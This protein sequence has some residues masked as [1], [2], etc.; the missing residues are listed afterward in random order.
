MEKLITDELTKTVI[1]VGVA[2]AGTSALLVKLIML[3]TKIQ[4]S[5]K[6]YQKATLNYLLTAFL[7]FSAVAGLAYW[8]YLKNQQYFFFIY[9]AC[10][11]LLG[12]GHVYGMQKY[13]KWSGNSNAFW[14]ELLFTLIAGLLGSI[15]FLIVHRF[16]NPAGLTAYRFFSLDGM[17]LYMATSIGFFIIP[18]FVNQTF[19]SAITIPPRVLKQWYYPYNE[20]IEEPDED[21][22]K[23]LLVISFEFPKQ[24]SDKHHT[25]FRAKAPVDMEMGELF[26]YF[27]NDYNERH[28]HDQ[29]D[30]LREEGRPCGWVFCK[31]PHFYTIQPRYIDAEKTI[32]NNGIK[33]ND[34]I[35][36]NRSL[37]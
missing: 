30:F 23:H 5:F 13:L 20:E 15:G 17:Q 24:L 26:Y 2:M 7:L 32:F 34:V 37:N 31:K 27:I 1:L 28:P 10:F 22:L 8:S 14:S 25:N 3:I 6:P 33:E 11:L 18:W 19:L 9:Q 36:C 21:K 16:F 29:I 4:G 12:I 35:I